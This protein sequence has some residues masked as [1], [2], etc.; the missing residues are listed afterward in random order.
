MKP[1]SLA[2]ISYE[3]GLKLL[4]LRKQ[5]MDAGHIRRMTPEALANA[6]PLANI[7]RAFTEKAAEGGLLDSLKSGI[8]GA[9]RGITTQWN[10]LDQAS[11][12]ALLSSAAGTGIGALGGLGS[13]YT[14]GEGNYLGRALRGGLAGGALGGGLGLA[15]NPGVADKLY[16]QGKSMFKSKAPET[17]KQI[18]GESP[19]EGS[20][21]R[22]TAQKLMDAA[23]ADRGSAIND[24]QSTATSSSPELVAAGLGAGTVGGTA[25]GLKKLHGIKS[26]DPQALSQHIFNRAADVGGKGKPP[27]L[28]PIVLGQ[29]TGAPPVFASLRGEGVLKDL[30]DG[31]MSPQQLASSLDRGGI[32]PNVFGN[33][34]EAVQRQL[35]DLVRSDEKGLVALTEA[36]T[37]KGFRDSVGKARKGRIGAALALLGL[38]GGALQKVIS[39]YRQNTGERADAQQALRD[40]SASTQSD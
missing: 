31:L 4:T 36:S 33:A 17:S 8:E 15:F 6:L 25:Y 1:V 21:T 14:S 7:G 3:Q 11:R 40:L 13:A 26:F 32:K 28:N 12:N 16:S 30:A 27:P 19:A 20:T 38:G 35:K 10:N 34:P 23:P 22:T 37:T 39:Q 5:A 29:M 2:D 9:G 18:E 24:L